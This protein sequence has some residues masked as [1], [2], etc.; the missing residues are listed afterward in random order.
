MQ[1]T[2]SPS[3]VDGSSDLAPC[4][5]P[6]SDALR[7]TFQRSKRRFQTPR[8]GSHRRARGSGTFVLHSNRMPRVH[9]KARFA[10]DRT[11]GTSRCTC[12]TWHLMERRMRR[13]GTAAKTRCIQRPISFVR[14]RRGRLVLLRTAIRTGCCG[15]QVPC[16][17]TSTHQ[18]CLR[19]IRFC[20]TTWGVRVRRSTF[21]KEGKP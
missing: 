21:F 18:I 2:P 11:D 1:A 17:L 5:C 8:R 20:G 9:G 6:R 4:P 13:S 16:C 12:R 3:N 7:T 19:E 15:C 14:N 10:S